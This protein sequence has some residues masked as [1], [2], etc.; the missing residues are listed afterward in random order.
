MTKVLCGHTTLGTSPP[1]AS[2]FRRSLAAI[3]TRAHGQEKNRRTCMHGVCKTTA[4]NQRMGAVRTQQICAQKPKNSRRWAAFSCRLRP[5]KVQETCGREPLAREKERES[6]AVVSEGKGKGK[7]LQAV[8]FAD[9]R[10]RTRYRFPTSHVSLTF[11]NCSAPV[12]S[13]TVFIILLVID[14]SVFSSLSSFS[15]F[16]IREPPRGFLI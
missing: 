12:W 1:T 16:L 5:R 9:H 14:R 2:F 11:D 8:E 4:Q 7:G 13:T 10:E 6:V 3:S 15:E